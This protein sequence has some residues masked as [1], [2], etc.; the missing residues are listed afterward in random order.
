MEKYNSDIF[1][2]FKPHNNDNLNELKG[3]D[4]QLLLV[5]IDNFYLDLRKNLNLNQNITF[6]LELEYEDIYR[7]NT[8]PVKKIKER[9]NNTNWIVKKDGS[10]DYGVEINSPILTDNNDTWI[11]LDELC[12]FLT[13]IA[14][15]GKKSGGHIHIGTQTLGNKKQSWLNFL[16]LWSVYENV[17]YRFTAGEFLT[18][19]PGVSKYAIPSMRTFY[20]LYANSQDYY[21]MNIIFKLKDYDR[22][23]AVNFWNVKEN[24]LNDNI[25]RNTIEFRSPNSSLNSTIWQNNVNFFVKMLLYCK[26]IKF[27]NDIIDQRFDI[28]RFEYDDLNLYDEIFLDQVLELVDLVFNNNIDKIYFLKQYLKTFETQKDNNEFKEVK[29]LIKKK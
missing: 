17:I 13:P 23:L 25:Y 26:S 16:K 8:L 27:N 28:N 15:V 21:L 9:L 22:H 18:S 29:D 14:T 20:K 10:L 11:F 5:L 24:N 1:K 3:R 12:N 19:R 4:L 7:F 2:Y 6:G